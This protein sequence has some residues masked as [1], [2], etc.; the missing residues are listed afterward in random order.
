MMSQFCPLCGAHQVEA[1][2]GQSTNQD[3]LDCA[4]EIERLYAK[5]QALLGRKNSRENTDH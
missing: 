4:E 2:E 3:I 5:L 1:G